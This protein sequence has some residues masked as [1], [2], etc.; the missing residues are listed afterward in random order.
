MA[1]LSYYNYLGSVE[2][3]EKDHQLKGYVQGLREETLTYTGKSLEE[4]ERNFR[5]VVERYLQDCARKKETPKKSYGGSLNVRLGPDLHS[6]AAAMAEKLDCTINSFIKEA[7]RRIL[8]DYE[9]RY[10]R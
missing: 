8:D 2:F 6:R 3:D 9:R 4:L 7:V 5:I 10:G 1:Y